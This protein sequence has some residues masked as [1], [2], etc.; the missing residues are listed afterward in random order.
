[1]N[2]GFSASSPNASEIGC[3]ALMLLASLIAA[4]VHAQEEPPPEPQ[5][6][7]DPEKQAC[8]DAY[9][10]VQE[11][12]LEGKLL[13]ARDK[14]VLCAK[15][16]CPSAVRDG[17]AKWLPQLRDAVPSLV[18]SARDGSGT[19]LV[20][21][22]VYVDEAIVAKQLTGR[23]IEVDP[24]RH[25]LRLVYAGEQPVN[26]S[27]LVVEGV[28][29][30]PIEVVIGKA[31]EKIDEEPPPTTEESSLPIGPFI[32]GAVGI[33]AIGVFVGL[34]VVGS[35]EVKDMRNTCAP[36]C[37]QDRID[38]ARAKI[39]A[40]DVVLFSGAGLIAAAAVWLI[41]DR[42]MAGGSETAISV[43]PARGLSV[44]F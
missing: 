16:S 28:K 20:D 10:R 19:D 33:A 2:M 14:A 24:G 21:V 1:M 29:N 35:N 8:A 30:R 3:I 7:A 22:T 41:I 13:A 32:V 43:D 27:V 26:M 12:R 40:G 25:A 44:R 18:V 6:E 42:A 5:P 17:C 23:P 34:A 11:L 9:E 4:P 15:S 31:P 38:S 36:A 37:E 39:I